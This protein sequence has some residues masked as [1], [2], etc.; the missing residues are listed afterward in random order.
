MDAK[1]FRIIKKDRMEQEEKI[2]KL[3]TRIEQLESKKL[4]AD[5]ENNKN[6][7]LAS[8]IAN[9]SYTTAR[10]NYKDDEIDL[11]ELFSVL[12]KAKFK[13]LLITALFAIASVV[14]ALSLPNIY[15][16]TI[17]LIPAQQEQSGG[18]SSLASQYGGLA[19]AAGINLGGSS[20]NDLQSTA[21]LMK[22]WWYVES[23]ITKNKLK[24]LFM[25]VVGW[26][27]ETKELVYD[28]KIYDKATQKW[29]ISKDN[30]SL[31]PNSYETYVRVVNEFISV[32]VD[33]DLGTLNISAK[34]YSPLVAYSLV[35]LLKKDIDN[36]ARQ[37]DKEDA[38]ASVSFIEMKILETNNTQIQEMLYSM[39]ESNTKKL[40]LTEISDEY[41]LRTAVPPMVPQQ[42]ALP[43]RGLI[44]V[45]GILLGF[46]ISCLLVLFVNWYF[47]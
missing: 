4:D 21:E 37:H 19:A 13:I 5:F 25:A 22:S 39:I 45:L 8:I 3:E 20:G 7:I 46:I 31:E 38:Q 33:E 23:F 30:K 28:D 44:I 36:Y 43:S 12:W 26:N 15:I 35:N 10:N 14:Y 42:K 18:L 47:Q 27:T 17:K 24:P 32:S 11:K 41:S 2:K 16:S 40:M 34:H 6:E 29:L 9:N 1:I